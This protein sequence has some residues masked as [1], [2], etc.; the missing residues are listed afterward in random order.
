MIHKIQI[1][2]KILPWIISCYAFRLH[3]GF[4]GSSKT[5]GLSPLPIYVLN[6][7]QLNFLKNTHLSAL[8][9]TKIKDVYFVEQ[10]H[11]IADKQSALTLFVVL[12]LLIIV[13]LEFRQIPI[14]DEY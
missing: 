4:T 14:I 13:A 1:H 7:S 9:S 3:N 8:F 10:F 5:R 2:P 6:N 12:P 11:I